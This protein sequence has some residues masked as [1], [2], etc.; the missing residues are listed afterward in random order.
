MKI[1]VNLAK[2]MSR[3]TENPQHPSQS[4]AIRQ[5]TGRPFKDVSSNPPHRRYGNSSSH[6]V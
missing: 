6:P 5:K 3:K 1:K 4:G 2:G